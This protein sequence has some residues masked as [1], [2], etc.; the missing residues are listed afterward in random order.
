M[1][2]LSYVVR[3]VNSAIRLAEEH[4][5]LSV[6]KL[7]VQVGEMTDVLP[8]YLHK[9][10]PDAT[11]GTILEDS[12]LETEP[13]PARV[14]C[15]SCRTEYHPEKETNYL[16]PQCGSGS[17]KILAGRHVLLKNVEMEIP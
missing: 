13:L 14:L 16:C 10:Y 7:T 8:E 5:A 6:Q 17:G 4:Q 15:G 12:I 3:F 1:H 2:E 9:Y 11:K